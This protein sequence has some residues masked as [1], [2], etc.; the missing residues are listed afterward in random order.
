M[1]LKSLGHSAQQVADETSAH[2]MI[3][4]GSLFDTRS[5]SR[6]EWKINDAMTHFEPYKPEPPKEDA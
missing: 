1:I 4:A 6:Q 3:Y 2:F 5:I